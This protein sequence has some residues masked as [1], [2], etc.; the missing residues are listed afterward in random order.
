M[1]TILVMPVVGQASFFNSLFSTNTTDPNQELLQATQKL[2]EQAPEM[3]VYTI[4]DD[5]DLTCVKGESAQQWFNI[6]QKMQYLLPPQAAFALV[7]DTIM[8]PGWESMMQDMM[9]IPTLQNDS[10]GVGKLFVQ[11]MAVLAADNGGEK[12]SEFLKGNEQMTSP[13]M[14][15]LLDISWDQY[16]TMWPMFGVFAQMAVRRG[17]VKSNSVE[18]DGLVQPEMIQFANAMGMG[19]QSDDVSGLGQLSKAYLETGAEGMQE[20]PLAFITVLFTRAASA[21]N[22]EEAKEYFLAAQAVVKQ[23]VHNPEDLDVTFTTRWPLWG[24]AHLA[25]SKIFA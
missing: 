3:P 12:I 20:S 24:M 4:P 16:Q 17:S 9:Q 6:Q 7:P 15:L 2:D 13:L 8:Q 21:S 11:L 10:C 23:L 5:I 18:I 22:A 19:I 14:T 1:L 25:A